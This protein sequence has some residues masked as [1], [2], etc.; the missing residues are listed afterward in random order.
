MDTVK[1]SF[2][3]IVEALNKKS[4][5]EYDLV[6]GIAYGGII[7]AALVSKKLNLPLFIVNAS[8]RGEDNKPIYS[9]PVVAEVPKLNGKRILLVDD[10]SRT[11]ATLETV[12]KKLKGNEVTTFVFNGK[13]DI[14][15]FNFDRCISWPWGNL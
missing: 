6:V 13:A 4:F 7:P 14:S 11:G 5:G 12:K 2:F 1:L 9:K 8:Y 3:S 15:L 10:V